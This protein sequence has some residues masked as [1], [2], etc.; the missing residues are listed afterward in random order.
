MRIVHVDPYF[1]PFYGGIEHRIHNIC[2]VLGRDNEVTIVTSQLPGTELEERGDGYDIVRLKSRFFGNYNP[3]Y[4]TSKG[5]KDTLEGLDPDI[6][7]F[8]YRWAPS[9]TRDMAAHDGRKVFCWHNSYGEGEGLLQR[10]GSLAND[11]LFLPRLKKYDAITCISEHIREQLIG[12]GVPSEKLEVIK[13]GVHMPSRISGEED[14]Y[15]LFVGRLV[16]TKGLRYLIEAMDEVE[17]PLKICGK[18]PEMERLA[19]LIRKRDV[20]DKVELLG[21]VSDDER[22]LLLDRCSV[23]VMPSIFEAYGIAAAEAMSHGKPLVA[24]A[25]GGLPEVVQD[26]GVLVPPRDPAALAE[27]INR[28]ISD[29]GTRRAMGQRS[30]ELAKSYSWE[31][32]AQQT[33]EQYR[34]LI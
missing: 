12:K 18:G 31:N 1:Y 19:S 30:L 34:R 14:G 23:Y 20:G 24:T 32:V 16:A 13:N 15:I 7:E 6:V 9:Y 21:F 26:A 5:L 22:D 27:G 28:L 3:P 25:T 17:M 11:R 8:H 33:L 29:D 10:A 4:V 2:S